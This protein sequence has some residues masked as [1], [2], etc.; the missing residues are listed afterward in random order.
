M[1]IHICIY[2]FIYNLLQTN[3]TCL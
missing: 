1:Y 2:I 3:W